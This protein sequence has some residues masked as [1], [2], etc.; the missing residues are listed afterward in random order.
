MW[1][2]VKDIVKMY[3]Q[4]CP[5]DQLMRMG[6]YGFMHL[7]WRVLF[8]LIGEMGMEVGDLE[9]GDEDVCWFFG[10]LEDEEDG[11]GSFG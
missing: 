11:W 10:E 1:S 6:G 3:N 9:D 2:A 4:Q 5:I 8:E 7:V